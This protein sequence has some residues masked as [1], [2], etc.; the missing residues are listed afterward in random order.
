LRIGALQFRYRLEGY[1][2]HW[3]DAGTRRSAFYTHLPP[4]QYR[5]RVAAMLAGAAGYGA[6]A[7]VTVQVRPY[8]YER[9]L[10]RAAAVAVLCLLLILLARW[11]MRTQRQRNAWLEAQ[12]ERR[13]EQLARA[14]ERLRVANLALAEESYT[15]TLTAVQ[16]RRYLL[17]RLPELLVSRG[18]IGLL[19]ID[20]DYFKE[21]NDR[22]GH[23]V[24]DSV[25]RE[26]G[27]MLAAARRDSDVAV[28]WGGEE[29]LLL[30]REVDPGE[31]LV[32]AERLRRDIAAREF[33]DSWGDK[34]VLTCSIGFSLH[35]LAMQSDKAT[36]DAA[37][38]LTDRALYDAK[39]G[40]RNRCVG[41]IATAVLAADVLGRPFAPQVD[42]LLAS[43]RLRWVR[44]V[45]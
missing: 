27:Q 18:P 33:T 36:F 21:I 24:G 17:A 16:N 34:V 20:I 22:H 42:A 11:G 31:V 23:A 12:V 10:V 9:A 41:L 1:D 40:G 35:P 3:E 19:Q 38:E 30:L 29:F 28:R 8:W 7:D 2:T 26:I 13:T 45:S 6:E 39:Q 5:F 4:G 25:L 14:L 37:L 44:P 15:D 32:I 43:G